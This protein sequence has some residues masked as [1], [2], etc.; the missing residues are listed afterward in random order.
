M[1]MPLGH[2]VKDTEL[3][4]LHLVGLAQ[5]YDMVGTYKMRVYW[6]KGY[7]YPTDPGQTDDSGRTGR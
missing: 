7:R 6:H 4:R 1:T 5:E 2:R 3:G